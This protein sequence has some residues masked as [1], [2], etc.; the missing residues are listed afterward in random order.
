MAFP[1]IPLIKMAATAAK[2]AGAVAKGA[3]VTAGTK[4]G[5]IAKGVGNAVIGKA[6][7]PTAPIP[8]SMPAS[9]ANA[10]KLSNLQSI[11]NIATTKTIEGA[12]ATQGLVGMLDGPGAPSPGGGP[13]IHQE[14]RRTPAGL[15]QDGQ[16]SFRV[17]TFRDALEE[18]FNG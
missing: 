17:R 4:G 1:L 9:A 6:A 11:A 10:A 8:A 18:Q 14:A 7:L 5:A 15:I 12:T 2:T 3:A 16:G 13:Q